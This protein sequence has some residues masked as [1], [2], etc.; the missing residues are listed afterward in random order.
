MRLET[1]KFLQLKQSKTL[2]VNRED[3]I[4]RNNYKNRH[5]LDILPIGYKKGHLEVL[6]FLG[7]NKHAKFTYRVKCDCGNVFLTQGAVLRNYPNRFCRKCAWKTYIKKATQK[8][9][10][11]NTPR[12]R[13]LHETILNMSDTFIAREIADY[14]SISQR[15]VAD[16]LKRYGFVGYRI[17]K[18]GTR[19]KNRK[20]P[21]RESGK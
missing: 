9:L 8:K 2:V 11:N 17:V 20:V 3:W 18:L 16:I 14:L 13:Q 1:Y 19:T 6:E 21:W 12:I 4:P 5:I 7:A 10:D 15:N